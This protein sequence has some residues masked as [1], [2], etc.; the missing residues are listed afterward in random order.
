MFDLDD[1]LVQTEKLKARS[2]AIAA[3]RLRGLQ[4]PEPEAVEAYRA[5]MERLNL[6]EE[7]RPRMDE[8][9]A[10]RPEQ[11]LTAMR[12]AIYDEMVADPQVVLAYQWPHTVGLLRLAK[13]AFCQT[14]QATMSQRQEAL[15]ILRILDLE[16]SLYLIL[17]REDV[18]RP[19]P[20]PEIYLL[21]AQRL[22]VPPEE[23]L[24][25]EDSPTGVQ[26][27]IAAG[28]NVIAVAT[29]FTEV[30]LQQS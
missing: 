23:C 20:D 12:K 30:G 7:L 16:K 9:G 1:T 13:A 5:V 17:T 19:K 8:Y 3:Q 29:P 15:H 2:Y 4:E 24:V 27:G 21:A 26:A 22:G 6:E 25:L 14:A 11:V 18:Q 10:K 28:A